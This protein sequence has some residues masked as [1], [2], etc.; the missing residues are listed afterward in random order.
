MLK[1]YFYH[2]KKFRPK[3]VTKKIKPEKFSLKKIFPWNFFL[4][5][6]YN[7]Q[8]FY[9]KKNYYVKKTTSKQISQKKKLGIKI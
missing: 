4:R 7:A 6:W 1:K 5:K 2:E 3:L 9:K 8:K